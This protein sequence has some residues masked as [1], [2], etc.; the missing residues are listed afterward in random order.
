[1]S[2]NIEMDREVAEKALG[3]RYSTA[4]EYLWFRPTD[5]LLHAWKIVDELKIVIIP[6]SDSAPRE[7][8]YLA[9][10]DDDPFGSLH[11]AFAETAQLAICKVALKWAAEDRGEAKK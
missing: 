10:I 5:N 11:E 4:E 9:Q 7:L 2:R 8:R 1:M 3:W 6:Q